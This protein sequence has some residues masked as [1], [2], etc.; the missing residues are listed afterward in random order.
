VG[1]KKSCRGA[2]VSAQGKAGKKPVEKEYPM[3]K[4][5]QDAAQNR[6]KKENGVL[7]GFKKGVD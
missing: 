6:G 1:F 2:A 7:G 4:A 3:E 5:T